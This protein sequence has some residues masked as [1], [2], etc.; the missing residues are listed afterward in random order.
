MSKGPQYV[1]VPP[2]TDENSNPIELSAYKKYF[3]DRGIEVN[4]VEEDNFDL[5]SGQI[6]RLDRTVGE[7]IDREKVSFVTIY[8][9]R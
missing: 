9:A 5:P 3:T 7:R 1:V 4:V 6:I 2:L 8:V